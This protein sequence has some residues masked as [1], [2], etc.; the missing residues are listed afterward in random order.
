MFACSERGNPTGCQALRHPPE[1]VLCPFQLPGQL[2]GPVLTV[3]AL[4]VSAFLHCHTS[5]WKTPL[6]FLGLECFP[7][8]LLFKDPQIS[9]LQEAFLPTPAVFILSRKSPW[10]GAD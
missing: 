6:L 4:T 3:L 2:K 7:E 5:L 8:G 10:R 9:P 1:Q